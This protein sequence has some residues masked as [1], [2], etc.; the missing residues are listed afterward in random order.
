MTFET[1]AERKRRENQA[2]APKVYVYDKA[3]AQLRHQISLAI[4]E[5]IGTYKLTDRYGLDDYEPDNP[6]AYE[7]WQE[8]DRICRKE[9]FSYLKYQDDE[10]Y[11][12]GVLAAIAD[13]GDYQRLA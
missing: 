8:I 6:I 3:P 12:G 5:G 9:I 2:G 10:D 1:F 4:V 7:C 11:K 13:M